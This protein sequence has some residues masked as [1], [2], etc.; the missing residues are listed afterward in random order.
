MH[1]CIPS[2]GESNP[3]AG[4]CNS[5]WSNQTP[6]GVF[7]C[8]WWILCLLDTASMH[9]RGR[10]STTISLDKQ[11][12]HAGVTNIILCCYCSDILEKELSQ[13]LVA[14]GQNVKFPASGYLLTYQS[15]IRQKKDVSPASCCPSV[16]ELSGFPQTEWSV[17][18]CMWVWVYVCVW[19]QADSPQWLYLQTSWLW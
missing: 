7:F 9:H 8:C 4:D 15:T 1:R 10:F 11:K 6:P 14:T 5:V 13:K 2:G 17:W 16:S 12:F 19:R 3:R 18:V